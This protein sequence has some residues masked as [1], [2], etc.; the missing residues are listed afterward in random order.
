MARNKSGRWW[1]LPCILHCL[2]YTSV[3]VGLAYFEQDGAR[4]A[5]QLLAFALVILLSHWL[6]DGF[7][8]AYYWSRWVNRTSL[9]SVRMVVDQTMHLAVLA[10]AVQFILL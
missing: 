7:R 8:F 4:Q 3:L 6:I 2:I 9:E 10:L 1:S 5:P